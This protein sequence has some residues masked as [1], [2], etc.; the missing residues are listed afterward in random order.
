[1]A[2]NRIGEQTIFF[3]NTPHIISMYSIVGRVEGQGPY[4]EYFH[5]ILA[6]DMV[7]QKTP[8]Q[9]E[10]VILERAVDKTLKS[11]ELVPAD[12][13]YH[14]SG[15]LLNQIIS[16]VF[17]ARTIGIPFLGIFGACATFAKGLG[18]G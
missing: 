18:L 5:E 3:S 12:I 8:E 11:K 1:M 16:S 14:L 6:D 17:S 15:D 9:A 10:R 4:A 7:D 13:Q 2:D